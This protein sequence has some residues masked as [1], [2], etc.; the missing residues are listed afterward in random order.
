MCQSEPVEED[1]CLYH[2]VSRAGEEE[3]RTRLTRN[4]AGQIHLFCTVSRGG[5]R[6]SICMPDLGRSEESCL[7]FARAVAESH[8]HPRILPELWEE[9]DG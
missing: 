3:I 4:G 7:A 2:F 8:T 5:T 6:D 9:E 1:L